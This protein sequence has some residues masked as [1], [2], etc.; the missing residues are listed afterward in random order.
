MIGDKDACGI[1]RGGV[2]SRGTPV[3]CL[4][5]LLLHG[6]TR[7]H[8][9]GHRGRGGGKVVELEGEVQGLHVDWGIQRI[10][11]PVKMY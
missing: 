9:V 5:L 11:V 3:P 8:E 1:C 4:L 10:M 7:L 2:W 6:G